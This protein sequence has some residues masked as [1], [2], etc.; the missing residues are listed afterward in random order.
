MYIKW[1]YNFIDDIHD[2]RHSLLT[3]I[4]DGNFMS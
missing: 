2:K 1:L 4:T 3:G